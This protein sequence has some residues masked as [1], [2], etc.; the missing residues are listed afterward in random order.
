MARK[1]TVFFGLAAILAL[2]LKAL[3]LGPAMVNRTQPIYPQ[4]KI[5]Y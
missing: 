2:A 4:R 1:Q 5:N 3:S